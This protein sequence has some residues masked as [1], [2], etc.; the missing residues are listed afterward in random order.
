MR[1]LIAVTLPAENKLKWASNNVNATETMPVRMIHCSKIFQIQKARRCVIKVFYTL[2]PWRLALT[3]PQIWNNL[4]G[5]CNDSDTSADDISLS[6]I[7]FKLTRHCS[8]LVV[9][10]VA[11][12]GGVI[13]LS[14][15]IRHSENYL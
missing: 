12:H 13:L 4:K 15:Q 3:T 9:P 14:L 8:T 10:V 11:V 1:T 2:I 6:D 7:S 5:P